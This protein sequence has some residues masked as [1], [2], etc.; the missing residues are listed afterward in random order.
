MAGVRRRPGLDAGIAVLLGGMSAVLYIRTLAPTVLAGD[1]GEFQFA[2]YLLGVAHPTGYP[3]Y[4][5]LGWAWSHL[6]PV[7]DAAYRL[8]LFSA[9]WAALAVGLFYPTAAA[10]LQQALPDLSLPVRRMV[11]ALA[12]AT[13]AVTPT[14]WSQAI[15]AEV[16]TLHTFFVVLLFYLILT[17]EAR[18]KKSFFYFLMIFSFVFGLSLTHHRTTLLLA[19]AF[20]AFQIVGTKRQEKELRAKHNLPASC[21]LLLVS[22]LLP[23]ALYAYIPLRAPHTPYL[24]LP[25][26]ADRELVLYDNTFGS[27]VGF[28]LGGPF[29]GSVNLTVNLGERL[30][31]AGGFLRDEVGW[32]GIGLALIGLFGL[33]LKHRWALLA[34]TGLA[35]GAVVAFNLVYTIGDI[36]VLFIPSYVVIVLWM[37]VGVGWVLEMSKWA[38]G[39]MGK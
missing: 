19:P 8:N 5:L 4:L 6:L 15:I 12:A 17:K 24:H 38:N 26:T 2:A 11:A 1:P 32:I 35:Y 7:G 34:L 20:L 36:F 21:L 9:F 27:F 23:L 13:L 25:L 29:G 37:A 28:V 33:F 3:L 30:A 39:Q 14:F 31:M 18:S 16:Y 10:W 22:F